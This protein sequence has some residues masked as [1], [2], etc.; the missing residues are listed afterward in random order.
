MTMTGRQYSI[1]AGEFEATV[2]AVGGGLRR[3]VHRG[4]DVACS[5][6]E[7]VRPPKGCGAVLVPW[8][9]RLRGGQ[10]TFD[11]ATQQLALTEPATR[12]AIHGLARWARW[13]AVRHEENSVTMVHDIV[14]QTGWPFEVSVEVTYELDPQS[15]LTVRAR[16]RNHGTNR[17]PFGAGF[18][19][20]LCCGTTPLE[21]VALTVPAG[22]RLVV[23]EAKV[24]VG[25][26]S[27][28][29]SEFDLR[30]G[31]KLGKLRLD[32]CF[33]DVE[34][35]DGRGTVELRAGRGGARLWFDET[36]GY[37]QVYTLE[38]FPGSECAGVAIEPM[39]CPPDAFNSGTGLIVLEPA[40]EWSGS[41]GVTPL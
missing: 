34:H 32:D 36:F 5:Y 30:A 12:N 1:A 29:G 39:T 27:V 13:N 26:G 11:G 10:Y 28:A 18:H 37:V 38:R 6:G 22:R 21:K 31:R 2:V 41:W 4:V 16:A 23:D 40:A 20:Y 25:A 35:T 33:T 17:A 9:N 24:P 3:F 19:P 14:P 7:D 15:G 8:P